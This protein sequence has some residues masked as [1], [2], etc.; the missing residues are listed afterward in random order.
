MIKG[1]SIK[2]TDESKEKYTEEVK[3]SDDFF[4]ES[5]GKESRKYGYWKICVYPAEYNPSRIPDHRTIKDLIIKSAVSLRGWTFPQTDQQ[6][7]SNFGKGRQSY[8]IWGRFIEGYRAY[9]SGLFIWRQTFWEDIEDSG[10]GKPVLSF[11]NIIES[12]T[13]FF[14]FFKRYYENISSESSLYIE[15]VLK[16]TK[17]RKLIESPFS[18]PLIY[19]YISKENSMLVEKNIKFIDIKTSYKEIANS[20]VREIFTIFNWDDVSESTI[21]QWQT[22]LIQRKT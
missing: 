20:V 18:Y 11:V 16:G 8:T 10:S 15:I 21:N 3:E 19:S 7:S 12:I 6:N 13:E 1:K 5:I 17:D 22:R 4:F 9:Q 14:L 2:P